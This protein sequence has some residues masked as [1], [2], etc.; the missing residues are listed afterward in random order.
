MIIHAQTLNFNEI[1]S[2]QEVFSEA[3]KLRRVRHPAHVLIVEDDPLTRRVVVGVLGESNA[4]IT[5]ENAKGA[6]ASY[7]LHAPDIVFLDIGL[8]DMDGFAVLDQIMMFDPEAFIVM[9]SS[10]TDSGSV[11]KAMNAGAKGFVF[12]PFKK[13]ELSSYIQGSGIYHRKSFM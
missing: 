12:K 13:E 4:M 3:K 1:T 10:H 2:L 8:P 5:E 7:L 11:N 9:F 6:V